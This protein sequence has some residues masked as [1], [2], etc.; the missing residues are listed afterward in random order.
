M[1]V[2]PQKGINDEARANLV[3]SRQEQFEALL[4]RHGAN[5]ARL[6]NRRG[7]IHCLFHHDEHASLSL[8]LD[9]AL[10]NCFAFGTR[11]GLA[12]LRRLLGGGRAGSTPH[13]QEAESDR[14]RARREVIRREDAAAARRAEAAPL[15]H[16]S[17][18]VRRCA[19]AA[20]DARTWAG[21]LGAEHPET[22]P[23]LE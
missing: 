20:R 7:L 1:T 8:D 2:V 14:E 6:R 5:L 21:R 12:H 13:H 23:L 16:V 18:F 11:G 9:R 15:W 4:L 19:S 22:W 17:D 10:F 3:V